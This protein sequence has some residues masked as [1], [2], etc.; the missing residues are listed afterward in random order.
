MTPELEA[1]QAEWLSQLATMRR[2][3]AD[4]KLDQPDKNAQPYGQDIVVDEEDLSGGSGS[5]DFWDIS[6]DEEDEYSSDSL[7]RSAAGSAKDEVLGMDWL[8]AKCFSF[9][10]RRSGLNAEELEGQVIALLSSD[11]QGN[12]CLLLVPIWRGLC[13]I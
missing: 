7:D 6:D 1:A 11:S 13:D 12:T 4:L 5:D 3:I 2:A 10:E 9:A 8:K